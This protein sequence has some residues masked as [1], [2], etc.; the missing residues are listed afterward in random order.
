MRDGIRVFNPRDEG[1][2]YDAAGVKEKF[3]VA[4]G[5][6][7]RRARADGRHDR[8]H[9][10]RARHRREGRARA[11]RHLRI[12]REPARARRARSRTSGIAKGC[13]ATSTT[14]RQSR[15]LAR[16]RTD[17]PVEFDP[18]GARATAA[19]RA[20]DAS[21][22]STSSAFRALVDEYAPTAD[23]IAKTYR[24]VNT[25]EELGAL[26]D[27]LT[28]RRTHSRC[29]CCPTAPPR[30]AR[31]SSGS[32]SRPRRATPTTCRSA[33]AALGDAARR[34]PLGA[35][36][37][38]AASRVLEDAAIGKVGHDLKFDA[39][40]LARH[41]V[42]A[43]RPR[44]STRCWRAT[45]STPT[46]IRASAR[47]P[48][49]RAH[50]LQGA[51]RGGRLRPRREGGV[52]R[53][54]CRSRRSLDYAGERADL[55]GQLA[56][57]VRELLANEQLD[58]RSTRTLELPLHSGAGRRRAR[59]RPHRRP[60]AR[61]AVAADRAGAGAADRADLRDGRRRVQHQLA[62]AAVAKSC[63]TSCSCRC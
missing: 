19:A 21:R 49:A 51:H 10:G 17:V 36:A 38:R 3:G 31:P 50:Q 11:D 34:L 18:D 55:A 9:Q 4:P 2:W 30:C 45:C 53:P 12:A 37:R 47:G 44:H 48:R 8:Q 56:P 52:A 25:P 46:P 57:I 62:E 14:A 26:A 41:G 28:A 33:I 58:G 42:D 16:I 6:G 13:S 43:A 24:V 39:I 59:R 20:S 15:E 61:G 5:A 1:T 27:R 40:V 22:S 54:T 60:G 29:A 32:R 35:G 63:S 23:T 7:R